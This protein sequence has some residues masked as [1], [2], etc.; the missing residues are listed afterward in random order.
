MNVII[1][2]NGNGVSVVY[3]TGELSI[4]DV[5]AKDCPQ[6]TIVDDSML[7]NRDFRNAWE[8]VS[9]NIVVNFI[10][11]KELTKDRIRFERQPLLDSLD[12]AYQRALEDG[13]DTSDIVAEKNRLR[14]ITDLVDSAQTL[15]EL[16][17]LKII[18]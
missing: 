16:K 5:K 3:P 7:P 18:N 8:L 12:L 13:S 15:D 17:N 11:A 1:F 4:E 14:A 6:G 9:N 10:K 2:D